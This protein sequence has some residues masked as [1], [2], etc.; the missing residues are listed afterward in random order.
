MHAELSHYAPTSQQAPIS[1]SSGR[2]L[3]TADVLDIGDAEVNQDPGEF[4][5]VCEAKVDLSGSKGMWSFALE[6]LDGTPFF[7]ATDEDEGDTNRLALW[8][9]VR[10]LEALP[11]PSA[12]TML[13]GSRYIIRSISDCLPRW[14]SANFQW[15]HFGTRL[16]VSNADLW[17]RVDRALSIHQVS[18]CCVASASRFGQPRVAENNVNRSTVSV[19]D[20][21]RRWLLAQCGVVGAAPSSGTLAIA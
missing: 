4:L 10:G 7:E 1:R 16:P 8:A 2:I 11:G 9:V 14:R 6:H 12:V 3:K 17:L 21:L 20:G 13:T 18:A 15:E 19:T 5:L